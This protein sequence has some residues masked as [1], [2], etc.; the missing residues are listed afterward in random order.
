MKIY[1]NELESL[2][3]YEIAFNNWCN[4]NDNLVF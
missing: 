3:I 1:F 4:E 2:G